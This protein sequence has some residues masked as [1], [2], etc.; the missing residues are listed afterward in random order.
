LCNY[1]QVLISNYYTGFKDTKNEDG[2]TLSSSGEYVQEEILLCSRLLFFFVITIELRGIISEKIVC[3]DLEG[4]GKFT[5]CTDDRVFSIFFNIYDGLVGN[6]GKRCQLML[7]QTFPSSPI[8]QACFHKFLHKTGCLSYIIHHAQTKV[9]I[10]FDKS[11]MACYTNQSVIVICL[12]REK[13]VLSLQIARPKK[14]AG[15][16]YRDKQQ[17]STALY[18]T[19]P[20]KR[21]QYVQKCMD[22]GIEEYFAYPYTGNRCN[23]SNLRGSAKQ[24]AQTDKLLSENG[25][26][27]NKQRRSNKKTRKQKN[28]SSRR[29][30]EGK[31][32]NEPR[33]NQYNGRSCFT[34]RNCASYA[35]NGKR[36][37]AALKR[38]QDSRIQNW[39]WMASEQGRIARISCRIDT[40]QI[41]KAALRRHLTTYG[42]VATRQSLTAWKTHGKRTSS[43]YEQH[44][45]EKRGLGTPLLRDSLCNK[46]S[47]RCLTTSR[48]CY[49]TSLRHNVLLVNNKGVR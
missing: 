27:T 36:S 9:N 19:L 13:L 18:R 28:D 35:D 45:S 11:V 30:K 5:N 49:T 4:A 21:Q 17:C 2:I 15:S 20:A 22:S 29:N 37:Q 34:F 14:Q 46:Y 47:L 32:T 41:E 8:F 24:R 33:N 16:L 1:R 6:T 3:R 42:F 12:W 7:R 31:E 44:T 43:S 10:G 25:H 40:R 39:R 26:G 38:L 48:F 23:W